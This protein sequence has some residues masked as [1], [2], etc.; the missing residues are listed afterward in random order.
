MG[1]WFTSEFSPELYNL[2][3]G[4][5]VGDSMIGMKRLVVLEVVVGVMMG[6]LE[7]TEVRL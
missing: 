5:G 2:D 1:W 4:Y 7:D 6:G 3:S